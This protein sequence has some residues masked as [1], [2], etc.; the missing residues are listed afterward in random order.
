MAE[1][2]SGVFKLTNNRAGELRSAE[3]SFRP[4]QGD[5]RVPPEIIKQYQLQEGALITGRVHDGKL[6][7]IDTIGGLTPDRYR[8]RTPFTELVAVNPCEK[9]DLAMS[10]NISM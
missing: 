4:K 3:N 6:T 5:I 1:T 9:F 7:C 10:G 8:E 2:G